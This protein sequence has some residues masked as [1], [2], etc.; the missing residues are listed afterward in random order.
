MC[1]ERETIKKN[2]EILCYYNEMQYKIDNLMQGVLKNDY[3]K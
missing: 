1:E 3:V 2:E